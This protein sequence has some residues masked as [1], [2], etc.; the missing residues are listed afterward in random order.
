[1]APT[2]TSSSRLRPGFFWVAAR[3]LAA[4]C[5]RWAVVVSGAAEGLDAESAALCNV[6]STRRGG[7]S[8]GTGSSR[9][10]GGG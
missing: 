1:M 8:A 6:G 5:W 7:G 10:A 2:A 4:S 9:C 3:T